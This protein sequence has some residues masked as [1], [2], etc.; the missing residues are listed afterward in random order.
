MYAISNSE[1]VKTRNTFRLIEFAAGYDENN[2]MLNNEEYPLMLDGFPMLLACLALNVL[3]PGLVLRGPDSEFPRF[4]RAEKKVL[5]QKKKEEKLLAKQ[6]KEE[7]IRTDNIGL[8][9]RGIGNTN[10]DRLSR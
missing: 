4:T 7:N 9:E 1:T 3:H 8:E 10:Y 5:K 6:A 2:V